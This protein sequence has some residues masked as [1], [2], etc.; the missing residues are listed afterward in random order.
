MNVGW[1]L[2]HF[3]SI[4]RSHLRR[5]EQKPITEKPCVKVDHLYLEMFYF[6]AQFYLFSF[7]LLT[8]EKWEINHSRLSSIGFMCHPTTSTLF[9]IRDIYFHHSYLHSNS[10]RCDSTKVLFIYI[11]KIYAK[12]NDVSNDIWRKQN[13]NNFLECSFFLKF[14][15]FVFL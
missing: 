9:N 11:E 13:T 6:Y 15:W 4:L 8:F 5:R 10:L 7:Y 1:Y 3:I 14:G 12:L 2:N